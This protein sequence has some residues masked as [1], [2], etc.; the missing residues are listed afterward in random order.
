MVA[1]EQLWENHD[2]TVHELQK[3][4]NIVTEVL[5]S[6]LFCLSLNSHNSLEVVSGTLFP[7]WSTLCMR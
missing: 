2:V 7:W 6:E 4:Q 1:N 3:K 5:R